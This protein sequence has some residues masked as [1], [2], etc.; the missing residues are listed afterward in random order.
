MRSDTTGYA[1]PVVRSTNDT[2]VEPLS[3]FST[4]TWPK[5]ESWSISR[6]RR[7]SRSLGDSPTAMACEIILFRPASSEAILSISPPSP[8]IASYWPW[9]IS[10]AAT[11]CERTD[12][13]ESAR[14]LEVCTSA[15]LAEELVAAPER[16]DHAFQN[17]ASC[18]LMPFVARFGERE[19]G[20]VERLGLR[21]PLAHV[22]VLRAV[23]RVQ[24]LVANAAEA[25]DV[26]AGAELR[27]DR[28]AVVR[29]R[30]LHARATP[31]ASP[32]GAS[33]PGWRRSRCCG[34]WCRACAGEPGG[35][36]GRSACRRRRRRASDI[37][38]G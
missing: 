30:E 15:C 31:A 38:W 16:S 17:L 33:S 5:P 24:E 2:F 10:W 22:R 25:G 6:S 28:V 19:L 32:P 21:G 27:A 18:A 9:A 7:S 3:R 34:R 35:P 1:V 4:E 8:V 37:R 36:S 12:W 20:A 23:L 11:I 26:D 14:P 13:I 29:E